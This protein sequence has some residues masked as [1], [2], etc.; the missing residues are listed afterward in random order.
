MSDDRESAIDARLRDVS[1]PAGLPD[2]VVPASLFDDAAIDRLLS[3][4]AVPAGL[5]DRVRSG[6]FASRPGL[7]DGSAAAVEP[8]SG[9]RGRLG[10]GVARRVTRAVIAIAADL[11]AAAAA[12]GLVAAMFLAGTALSRRM[13]APV[14]ARHPVRTE[15]TGPEP[16]GSVPPALESVPGELALAARDARDLPPALAGSPGSASGLDMAGVPGDG[17][18]RGDAAAVT[19]FMTDRGVRGAPDTTGWVEQS[20]S[21]APKGMRLVTLPQG[22]RAVPRSKGF[23]LVFEMTHGESPFVDPAVNP[24]LAADRPPLGLRADAFD[25]LVEQAGRES[26]LRR[27][28]AGSPRKSAGTTGGDGIAVEELLA[29][30]P[31]PWETLSWKTA[32]GLRPPALGQAEA[33]RVAIAAVPSL[34]AEPGSMLVDICVAPPQPGL[35]AAAADTMI[36]LDAST[37]AAAP[38]SWSGMCRGLARIAGRMRPIDRVSV[39]VCGPR[40]R[41]AALRADAA[42]IRRLLSELETEPPASGGD[43]DAAVRLVTTVSRREGAFREIVIAARADTVAR[44]REDA[45]TAFSAWRNGDE[46]AAAGSSPTETR[47]AFVVVDPQEPAPDAALR[48]GSAGRVAADAVS[49]ARALLAEFEGRPTIAGTDCRLSIAFDPK[50]VGSYRII[51]FRQ[52]AAEAVSAGEPAAIDMHVGEWARVV[53]E[54]VRRPG[55]APGGE[56]VTATFEWIPVG[57]E[58][59]QRQRAGWKLPAAGPPPSQRRDL[60]PPAACE[61]LLAVACGEIAA[62]S[63]HAEPRRQSLA[64]AA[65]VASRWRS[66]GDLT[67]MGILLIETLHRLGMPQESPLP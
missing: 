48:T 66:R 13:A 62:G 42:A 31:P 65:V 56:A 5:A 33:A 28:R 49:I 47:T 1:V 51:G 24:P 54:V 18:R 60:P 4:V 12:L 21:A 19:P 30:L 34:R 26:R 58:A 52:T 46:P 25:A 57:G 27:G 10:M 23:D 3:R 20:R 64:A 29:A 8:R 2:R 22:G 39:V 43:L 53:Y 11:G 36:V 17:S 15:R 40:P 37:E 41:L 63:P 9:P 61:L 38:R 14:A 45:R 7:L 55:V 44:C 67:P 50:T 6:C 59:P 16:V 35:A 32:A